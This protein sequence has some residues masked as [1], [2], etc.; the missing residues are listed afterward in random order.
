MLGQISSARLRN[1]FLGG[2][3]RKRLIGTV[4]M[5]LI[6]I[7]IA[8]I[9]IMKNRPEIFIWIGSLYHIVVD[10]IVDNT[11]NKKIVIEKIKGK[12][13]IVLSNIVE[14][15]REEVRNKTKY[16]DEYYADGYP[17]DDI[18]VCTDVVW[19]AFKNAGYNLKDNVDKDIRRSLTDYPRVEMTPD[20]NIDFR[21]VDNLQVFF[22]KYAK[23]LTTSLRPYDHDNLYQWQGGDIVVFESHIGIVSDKRRN[24]GIPY[25]IHNPSPYP[26]EDN[27]LPIWISYGPIIG[28]YRLTEIKDQ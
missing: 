14:G 19:R 26:V 15:A 4:V 16:Q 27:T 25:F 18:G 21:R 7:M 3:M 12:D 20:P 5:I 28:H 6:V 23:S 22:K 2:I 13:G 10:D 9:S 17:P 8:S 11:M 1:R 24:N